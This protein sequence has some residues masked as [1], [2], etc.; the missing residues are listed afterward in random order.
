MNA[1]ENSGLTPE[2]A[3]NAHFYIQAKILCLFAGKRVIMRRLSTGASVVCERTHF[4]DCSEC[5]RVPHR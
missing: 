2:E 1:A 4:A 5:N 3:K